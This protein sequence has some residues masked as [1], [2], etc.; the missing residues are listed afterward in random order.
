M[1]DPGF[2]VCC[3]AAAAGDGVRTGAATGASGAG[4]AV[5]TKAPCD[6]VCA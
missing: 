3:V 2:I 4:G 6:S 5:G 1:L